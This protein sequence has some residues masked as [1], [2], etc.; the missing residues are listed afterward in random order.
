MSE[1]VRWI[2]LSYE[3]RRG[4]VTCCVCGC[5]ADP[6]QGVPISMDTGLIVANDYDGDWAGKPCCEACYDRHQAGE[7]TGHDPYY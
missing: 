2:D 4:S 1:N 6:R 5:A 7:L 3:Y